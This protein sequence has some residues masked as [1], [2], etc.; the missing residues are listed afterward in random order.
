LSDFAESFHD[1]EAWYYI[2]RHLA[3]L[4]EP[5]LAL[6]LLQRA[7]N[8][9]YFCYPALAADPWLEALRDDPEFRAV[10]MTAKVRC[11]HAATRFASLGG[12]GLLA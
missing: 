4:G 9:G 2:A 6:P 5:G 8:G 1:P 12:L 3:H 11:E 7:V 10:V